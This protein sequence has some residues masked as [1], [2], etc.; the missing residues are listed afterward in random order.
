MSKQSWLETPFQVNLFYYSLSG[1]SVGQ[2]PLI[3]VLGNWLKVI[4]F[5]Q[6]PKMRLHDYTAG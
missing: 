1:H 4:P 2:T 6:M 5:V 3:V